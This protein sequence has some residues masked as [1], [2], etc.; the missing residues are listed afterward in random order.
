M[1]TTPERQ[2][3]TTAAAR[4][5]LTKR[6]KS[7]LEV[8]ELFMVKGVETVND[9]ESHDH[10]NGKA[11]V[12]MDRETRQ[13]NAIVRA[14]ID[15]FDNIK[16]NEKNEDGKEFTIV[17]SDK[18]MGDDRMK[19]GD[20]FLNILGAEKDPS[21]YNHPKGEQAAHDRFPNRRRNSLHIAFGIPPNS[22]VKAIDDGVHKSP[23]N[24]CPVGTVPETT[25]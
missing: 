9:K 22:I 23:G 19:V 13:E 3:R 21:E 20:S 7:E 5:R 11:N 2:V 17:R 4:N 25:Q 14:A 16:W 12:A 1:K 6:A 8:D 15:P 24:K 10:F 18:A